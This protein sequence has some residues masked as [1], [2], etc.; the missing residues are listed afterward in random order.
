MNKLL[1]FLFVGFFAQLIDGSLG[2]AYGSTSTS[3]LLT[4]GVAPAI[5]SSSVHIAEIV[6]TGVSGISHFK[7]G[8]VDSKLVFRLIIP[9]AA[10][11]FTGAC[12]LSR[13][14]GDLIKPYIS[15]LLVILG[16]YIVLKYF[17]NFNW[18]S[19]QSRASNKKLLPLGLIAGFVDSIGG[20][21][22]GTIAT[23]FLL[24]QPNMSPR[25][26]I[27]SVDS[28]EFIVTI[29]SSAGF[30]LSIGSEQIN[31][32]WVFILMAGGLLAAPLA[33]WLVKVLPTQLLGVFV[34]G[35]IILTNTRTI[36]S[37]WQ[38]DKLMLLL[39]YGL[40]LIVFI[41][42]PVTLKLRK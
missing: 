18:T 39:I 36:F 37:A 26:V 21:G 9:G 20:G 4:Y 34:G 2:M 1:V 30:L 7:L 3:L 25:K 16:I 12:F 28:S 29:A 24:T 31:W 22:W 19:A 23:P 14:P 38:I 6:T 40:I 11:A 42:L 35:I 33:A 8:N 27:G 10:G 32:S 41:A 17:L 5:A 13:L 15:I